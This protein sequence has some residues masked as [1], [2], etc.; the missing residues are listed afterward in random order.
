MQWVIFLIMWIGFACSL[1]SLQTQ[2]DAKNIQ[3]SVP[4][5]KQ[6]CTTKKVNCI[7]NCSFLCVEDQMECIG[8]ICELEQKKP[9]CDASKGG[10]YMMV[11][12]PVPHWT[13]IC[14]N[15]SFFSGRK[16]DELNPDVCEKGS[17]VYINSENYHCFCNWPYE[18]FN[19]NGK[20]HCLHKK[21]RLFFNNI[22]FDYDQG[23]VNIVMKDGGVSRNP[24]I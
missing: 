22:N 3:I 9:P 13:C 21:Y 16:C 18:I 6:N 14:T 17:L 12:D 19:V 5:F 15:P 8:G 11:D 20:P 2:N 10:V 7:N 24:Y 1:Q 23:Y 4:T